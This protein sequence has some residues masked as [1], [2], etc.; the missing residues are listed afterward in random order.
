ME[1]KKVAV[2]GAGNLGTSI[3]EGIIEAK[4]Y[5]PED[6]TV[7]NIDISRIE[8]L[9]EYGVNIT[10][11]N[12]KAVETSDIVFICVKPATT[13][14]ILEEIRESLNA[15]K[16]LL[17]SVVTGFKLEQIEEIIPKIPVVRAMP[18]TAISVRQS[19]TAICYNNVN[20][21]Q[22]EGIVNIFNQL[23]ETFIIPESFMPSATVLA[24][25]GIAFALRF[26]RAVSQGGIEIG[27][28]S[29]LSH[30]VAAQIMKGASELIIKSGHHP[31]REID[32]VTT[33]MGITISGLNEMEHKG[34]SSSL[35]KGVNEAHKKI[36]QA[37]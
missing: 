18:N 34:F 25:C 4:L 33:P 5:K 36:K 15:R 26:M 10:Q 8:Y 19:M 20:P 12:I 27:F 7:T 13:Q 29:E 30:K 32:K 3:V 2:L 9:K 17:V 11:D 28:G 1:N 21:E 16:H 37:E 35:I 24:S 31:E 22:A 23:G 14:G 6:I